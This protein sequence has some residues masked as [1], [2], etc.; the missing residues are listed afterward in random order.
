MQYTYTAYAG[1]ILIV[2]YNN[3][4]YFIA[5]CPISP[6]NLVGHRQITGSYA[7]WL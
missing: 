6:Y 4:Y 3:R 2:H 7:L 5:K 1:V